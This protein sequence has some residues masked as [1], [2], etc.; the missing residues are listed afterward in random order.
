[1]DNGHIK[2]PWRAPTWLITVG[3]LFAYVNAIFMGAGAKVWNPMA[4]WAGLFTA[5]L[6]IPV[7][8]YRHY[9]QDGGKFPEH[10]L[11]DLGMQQSDLR[12]KKAG[13]LPYLTLIAGL[14][15]VLLANWFF[16]L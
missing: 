4:L 7:F 10:M 15:V 3:A 5:A 16:V 14:A 6:I 11:E 2:R 9:I 8:C 1:M 12:V 13:I